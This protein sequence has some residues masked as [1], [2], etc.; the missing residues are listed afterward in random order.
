M[1]VPEAA[2]TVLLTVPSVSPADRT[3]CTDLLTCETV[4]EVNVLHV[5][6]VRTPHDRVRHWQRVE[7]SPGDLAILNVDTHVRSAATEASPSET[8]ELSPVVETIRNPGDLTQFGVAFTKCL[9]RWEDSERQTR[10]CFH[11]LSAFLHYVDLSAAFKF[12][13]VVRGQLSKA[14]AVGHFHIE[15]GAHDERTIRRL[16]PLF[17]A[18]V[19]AEVDGSVEVQSR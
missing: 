16:R 11:S 4:D 13:N 7:G 17:D 3:V 14:G 18:V 19:E 15:P 1:E 2:T 9:E 6:F 8:D 12:L 10:V 5:D